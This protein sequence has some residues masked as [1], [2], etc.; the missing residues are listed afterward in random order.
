MVFSIALEALRIPEEFLPKSC[1]LIYLLAMLLDFRLFGAG[2]SG[3]TVDAIRVRT[4]TCSSTWNMDQHPSACSARDAWSH[5]RAVVGVE[6]SVGRTFRETG[7][8]VGSLHDLDVLPGLSIT[9]RFLAA[10]IDVDVDGRRVRVASWH[11]PNGPGDGIEG[12]MRGYREVAAW[13]RRTVSPG[14]GEP[15]GSVPVVLGADTNS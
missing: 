14:F 1:E 10:S 13:G 6:V 5:Q 11:A 8:S 2:L 7:D 15:S 3:C 9:E 12:R 4:R